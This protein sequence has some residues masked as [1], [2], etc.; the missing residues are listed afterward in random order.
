[1]F[2]ETETDAFHEND[3]GNKEGDEQKKSTNKGGR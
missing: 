1:M 3:V 2:G